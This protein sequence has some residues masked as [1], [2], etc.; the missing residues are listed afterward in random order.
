MEIDNSDNDDE[1]ETVGGDEDHDDDEEGRLMLSEFKDIQTKSRSSNTIKSYNNKIIKMTRDISAAVGSVI[2]L[3]TVDVSQ[4]HKFI[5]RES[6]HTKGKN[7]GKMKSHATIDGYKN[8]LTFYFS[9]R[10]LPVPDGIKV[11]MKSFLKGYK[12][13]IA[14][15][16]VKGNYKLTEGKD[17]LNFSTFKA[18]NKLAFKNNFYDGHI[19]FTLCWNMCVRSEQVAHCNFKTMS[20]AEDSIKIAILK[21]KTKQSGADR[22]EYHNIHVY[23]NPVNP[24][25]DVFLSLGIKL[26]CTDVLNESGDMFHEKN[27]TQQ[28]AN[29]LEN[30]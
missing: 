30:S 4:I 6:R 21:E 15:E 14:S 9:E 20:W 23:S 18:I 29:W 10:R 28:Y 7:I 19:F 2:E 24:E 1:N 17:C 13:T 16:K 25:I 3:H 5:A 12:N 11:E 26:I 27:M 22:G 8:A